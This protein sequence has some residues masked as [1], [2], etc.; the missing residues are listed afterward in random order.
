M[1][2]H[3]Y[4]RKM[5]EQSC[6]ELH[7]EGGRDYSK[8]TPETLEKIRIYEA[9]LQ[10]GFLVARH[11]VHMNLSMWEIADRLTFFKSGSVDIEEL[12]LLY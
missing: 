6:P 2:I 12:K 7:V 1:K 11:L 3:E 9:G 10:K 8:D 5:I 4:A